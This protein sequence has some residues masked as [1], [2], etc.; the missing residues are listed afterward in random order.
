MNNF[1]MNTESIFGGDDVHKTPTF[2]MLHNISAEPTELKD[3]TDNFTADDVQ[4][5]LNSTVDKLEKKK[6]VGELVLPVIPISA[7]VSDLSHA[8]SSQLPIMT[9]ICKSIGG[10]G[11]PS[12]V[13]LYLDPKRYKP[14]EQ[15][16]KYTP[17]A[18]LKSK[19]VGDKKFQYECEDDK[20]FTEL[21]DSIER[22]S[23]ENDCSVIC[24]GRNGSCSNSRKFVC[25]ELYRARK[26][27]QSKHDSDTSNP[28]EYRSTFMIKN[29]KKGRREGGK[30]L[31]RRRAVSR[32]LMEE[33]E[34]DDKKKSL[35]CPFK[36]VLKWDEYGYF[37]ELRRNAGCC[38]LKRCAYN[39][40]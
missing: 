30:S 11:D 36:V 3:L 10:G 40:I 7:A 25:N 32:P 15:G 33:G 23:I 12:I 31:P 4:R 26:E 37:F 13:A 2:S 39:P 17:S 21:K 5:F 27:C 9:D 34:G 1:K 6:W 18:S 22:I 14:P 29:D 38:E 20:V 35:T 16:T 24:N 28:P 8:L 19:K